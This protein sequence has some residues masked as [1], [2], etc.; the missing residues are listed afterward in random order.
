M[1]YHKTQN[2]LTDDTSS[3]IRLL[4][5]SSCVLLSSRCV[6]DD[7]KAKLLKV[8]LAARSKS[9]QS[10]CCVKSGV[11]REENKSASAA[12]YLKGKPQCS[13]H[14]K[15]AYQDQC[16]IDHIVDMQVTSVSKTM[17]HLHFIKETQQTIHPVFPSEWWC[18]FLITSHRF[19]SVIHTH[20]CTLTLLIQTAARPAP[21]PTVPYW[22]FSADEFHP[23]STKHQT[24]EM[25]Q[26]SL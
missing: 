17:G 26:Q 12:C 21:P 1:L 3:A 9:N 7:T 4:P 19:S 25:C 23:K 13:V 20:A 11:S 15:Q 24:H 8:L 16:E 6:K 5:L 10:S 14:P 2:L 22:K 18:S